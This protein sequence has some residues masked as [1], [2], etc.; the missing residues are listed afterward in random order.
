MNDVS[1]QSPRGI[2]DNSNARR[3]TNLKVALYFAGLGIP[4][5]PS[6]GKTPLIKGF[7]RLDT[8][9]TS[10][11]IARYTAQY[12]EE[13]KD[14]DRRNQTPIHVGATTNIEVVKR[15]FRRY[16][17]AVPS[18]ACG[19]AGI[20]VL[21][22]DQKDDGPAKLVAKFKEHLAEISAPRITTQSGGF[23]AYYAN[24]GTYTNK[25]GALKK[26]C[27]T[28]V[29]GMGGQTVAPG[30]WRED[31]KRYGTERDMLALGAAWKAGLP[32]L[33]TFIT[34]MIAQ[35]GSESAVPLSDADPIVKELMK[36][37]GAGEWPDFEVT[38][39]ADVGKYC[40]DCIRERAPEFGELYDAPGA[41]RSTNRFQMARYLVGAIPRFTVEEYASFCERWEGLATSLRAT[42]HA[43]SPRRSG[44]PRVFP[45]MAEHS[46]LSKVK[47][48][49]LKTLRRSVKPV[50]LSG[51]S[52]ISRT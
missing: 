2:V 49:R 26:D 29:R 50:R 44:A 21:D 42:L 30:A 46:V 34:E 5:F 36:R 20:V 16:R 25:A 23:H 1:T 19:P 7:N 28:D 31:G 8:T 39:D 24:D 43:S 51:A 37:L 47:T 11:E 33:P 13:N 41:D 45:Q 17:D 18:I 4:V 27:G 12:V 52:T 10:E 14:R 32:K 38:F 35:G 9:L 6:S 40:L 15:M 22:A 3:S 48:T